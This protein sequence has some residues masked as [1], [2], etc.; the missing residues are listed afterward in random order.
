MVTTASISS[1]QLAQA[2]LVPVPQALPRLV[3]PYHQKRTKNSFA[4]SRTP[5]RSTHA[6]YSPPIRLMPIS[7]SELT[8]VSSHRTSPS[9]NSFRQR[10][11][12]KLPLHLILSTRKASKLSPQAK[13]SNPPTILEPNRGLQPSLLLP[14]R[15]LPLRL[16]HWSSRSRVT[17]WLQC[18][19]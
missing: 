12:F 10:K 15:S 9:P 5:T 14:Q 13:K 8:A 17:L 19:P 2:V 11:P 16:E 18:A 4:F 7:V 3:S 6:S 1:S